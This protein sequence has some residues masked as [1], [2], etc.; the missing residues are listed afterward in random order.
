MKGHRR[1]VI[2]IILAA[3][4]VAVFVASLYDQELYKTPIGRVASINGNKVQFEILNGEY[5]GKYIEIKHDTK[6]KNLVYDN[7]YKV[8]IKY[9]LNVSLQG[10]KLK[11]NILDQ[12]RDSQVVLLAGILILLIIA[13]GKRSGVFTLVGILVNLCIYIVTIKLYIIGIPI[14]FLSL[15]AMLIVTS[16]LLIMISGLSRETAVAIIG[17]LMTVCIIGIITFLIIYF[18]PRLPYD[19]LD[20]LPEPF[21]VW[22]ANNMLLSQ[23]LIASL[24]ATIDIAV[25][26]SSATKEMIV[27]HPHMSRGRLLKSIGVISEDVTGLMINVMFFVNVAPLLSTMLLSMKNDIGFLTVLDNHGFFYILRFLT[28]AISIVMAIPLTVI[29]ATVAW[30]K[31]NYQGS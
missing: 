16:L 11:G 30:K 20:F 7:R 17:T 4:L 21:N 23:V 26:V 19:Y 29:V 6:D 14:L 5:K 15:F 22:D 13:F 8:N 28:G 18:S 3:I 27:V 1:I 9:F 31:K 2:L 10:E 24:G 25:T 12:K